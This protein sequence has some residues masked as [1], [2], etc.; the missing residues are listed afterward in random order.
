MVAQNSFICCCQSCIDLVLMYLCGGFPEAPP[1]THSIDGDEAHHGIV[2]GIILLPMDSLK[3]G[4][5]MRKAVL[6]S[7]GHPLC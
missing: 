3:A 6:V 1:G 4:F 2:V 7:K 5:L